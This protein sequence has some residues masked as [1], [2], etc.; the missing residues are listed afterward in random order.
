VSAQLSGRTVL[1]TGAGGGVGRGVALA[2]ASE[3]AHVVVT[4]RGE[5][6]AETVA[7]IETRGG[8]AEWIRCDVTRQSDVEAAVDSAVASTG[9][10]DAVVHNATSRRSSEPVRLE[11]VDDELWEEHASVSLRAAYYCATAARPHLEAR[12]GRLLLMTSPAGMEGSPTLPVYGIVKGALRGFAKSLAREWGPHGVTVNL[13]SP[14][15]ETPAL[16]Q[17]MIEDPAMRARLAARIPLGRVGDSETDI[18]PVVAFLLGEG[19]RY[20][21]GQTVVV[22]GGRFM[23]L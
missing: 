15:A 18:G 6:G 2:C 1:V 16:E 23:G 10:L 8:A 5:N 7:L 9:G 19:A 14:L 21:T 3:G 11:A 12:R 22:D 20:I 4:S 13:V 17:A